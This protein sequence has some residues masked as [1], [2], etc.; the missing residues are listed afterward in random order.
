[1]REVRADRL[2]L[3]GDVGGHRQVLACTLR[4]LGGDVDRY[5][6]PD[7]LVVVQVGDLVG[8]GEQDAAVVADVDNWM[9]RNSDRWFQLLGNWESRHLGGPAFTSPR[10]DRVELP[11]S[12]QAT[13]RRWVNDDSARIAL[14]FRSSR[15]GEALVTH[16]GLTREFWEHELSSSPSAQE[17]A[18]RLNIALGREPDRVFR[19]GEML[20]RVSRDP[21]GPVWASAAE[22]WTSWELH[23]QPFNQVHGHT[24]PY[25]YGRRQWAPEM[26]EHLRAEARVDEALR[27]TAWT[28][29]AGRRI[30]TIDPGLGSR[31]RANDL[32]A[33]VM[34]SVVI[35]PNERPAVSM[36]G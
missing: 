7:D 5:L 36:D 10:R 4:G 2:A 6:L 25:F 29:R 32:H 21:P 35:L 11:S 17:C 27:H 14:A 16:A 1:M 8:G 22:V 26:P 9:Q 3:I 13:L 28:D 31:P 18:W 12:A 23:A 24:N 34:R 30:V 20:V 19:P 33:L 15:G